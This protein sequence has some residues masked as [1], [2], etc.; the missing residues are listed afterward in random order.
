MSVA[1]HTRD[2]RQA[3]GAGTTSW[4]EPLLQH[5]LDRVDVV[6]EEKAPASR[7]L[8]AL[9]VPERRTTC[10]DRGSV[11]GTRSA[12]GTSAHNR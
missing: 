4:D 12:P 6:V 9:F 11:T 2:R 7:Q 10:A 3:R 1:A 8:W 5:L